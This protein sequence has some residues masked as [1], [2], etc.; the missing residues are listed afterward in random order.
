MH[1]DRYPKLDA[2]VRQRLYHVAM[3][4]IHEWKTNIVAN[5]NLKKLQE[6]HSRAPLVEANTK[7]LAFDLEQKVIWTMEKQV[8]IESTSLRK[9]YLLEAFNL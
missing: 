8:R 3:G 9:K 5:R 1:L 4:L 6:Q 2:M 7:I